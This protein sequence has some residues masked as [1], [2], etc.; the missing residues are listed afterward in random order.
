MGKQF[1]VNGLPSRQTEI[2]Y[3]VLMAALSAVD[4]RLAVR[5]SLSLQ[6][7]KLSVAGR[8]IDLEEFHR[9]RLVGVGKASFA[10]AQGALDILGSRVTDGLLIVKHQPTGENALP[11]RI[12]VHQG[13]HPVPAQGSISSTRALEAYLQNSTPSDLVLCLISGGGSALM[14]LPPEDVSLENIQQLTRLLLACGAEIGEINTLRKHL[15]RVK[16]GG[17]AHMASPASIVTLSSF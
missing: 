2:V 15:D 8:I 11:P 10:M 5:R 13:D 1:S 9:I 12:S 17:L 14:T 16:G 3:S 4:P 7:K 6:G